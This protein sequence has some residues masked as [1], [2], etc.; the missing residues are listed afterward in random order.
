MSKHVWS[1]WMESF[2]AAIASGTSS[3]VRAKWRA[4]RRFARLLFGS[5]SGHNVSAA[6]SR[7]IW[8]PGETSS[9]FI[10]RSAEMRCQSAGSTRRAS[11][12]TSN[13]PRTCTWIWGS[14]RPVELPAPTAVFPATA[15][16]HAS[17]G[18][19]DTI[20]WPHAP[21]Q[22][23]LGGASTA[24]SCIAGPRKP[25]RRRGEPG[26]HQVDDLRPAG[27]PAPGFE[28]LR[29]PG[30]RRARFPRQLRGRGHQRTQAILHRIERGGIPNRAMSGQQRGNV[31]IGGVASADAPSART[32]D[33]FSL[34]LERAWALLGVRAEVDRPP[35]ILCLVERLG[36]TF[37]RQ[38]VSRMFG[39]HH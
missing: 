35:Q 33:R 13:F 31:R 4:L 37:A 15:G 5:A 38:Q 27:R 7:L 29:D 23:E 32:P 30:A 25:L 24:P 1:S 19:V 6:T 21:A 8:C 2:E 39:S 9:S 11:T 20:R 16:P 28:S 18:L 3:A 10:N 36:H 14:R 26:D 34:L 17:S 12:A 22:Y